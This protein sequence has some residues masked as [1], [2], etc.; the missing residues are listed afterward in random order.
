M[1]YALGVLNTYP[2]KEIP[3]T[4]MLHIYQPR[5]YNTTVFKL[6]TEQLL[7]WGNTILKP[8]AQMAFN[9]T[10]VLK[11]GKWC[12]FCKAKEHCKLFEI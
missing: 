1:I 6:T 3:K 9:G 11:K 7:D 8:N 2:F 4:I 10:G 5:I 12:K